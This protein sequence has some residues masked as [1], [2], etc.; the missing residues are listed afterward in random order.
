[1]P[2]WCQNEIDPT[3]APPHRHVIAC[4]VLMLPLQQYSTKAVAVCPRYQDNEEYLHVSTLRH[5]KSFQVA[6]E[7]MK[8]A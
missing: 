8:K 6:V 5:M 3:C 1:M 7:K 4:C 2:S